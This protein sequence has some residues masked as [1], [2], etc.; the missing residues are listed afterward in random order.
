MNTTSNELFELVVA[1]NKRLKIDHNDWHK[2]KNDKNRRA[3]E[4]ISSALCQLIIGGNE[5]ESIE[6]LE[7]SIKWIKGEVKNKPCPSNKSS[8]ES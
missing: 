2:L 4:L 7:E 6:Y 5:K 3:S 8:F 1:L